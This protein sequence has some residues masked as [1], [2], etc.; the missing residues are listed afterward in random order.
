MKTLLELR[1][2]AWDLLD[3]GP[4]DPFHPSVRVNDALNAALADA[5]DR[6]VATVGGS[7]YLSVIRDVEADPTF[8]PDTLTFPVPANMLRPVNI[9]RS[10]SGQDLVAEADPASFVRREGGAYIYVDGLLQFSEGTNMTGIDIWYYRA[11][12][13]MEEDTH[14]PDW[15]EGKERYL[16]LRACEERMLKGDAGN[17]Q[18]FMVMADRMWPGVIAAARATSTRTATIRRTSRWERNL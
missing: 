5:V 14:T 3:S 15:I 13:T 8:D 9:T 4:T 6:I 17:P 1:E 16:V 12:D 7:R 18:G 10:S 11:P 2:L